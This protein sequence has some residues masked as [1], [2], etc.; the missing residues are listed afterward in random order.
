MEYQLITS[1]Q[2]YLT[3]V[4]RWAWIGTL[5]VIG[6]WV[7]TWSVEQSQLWL[8]SSPAGGGLA[9]QWLYDLVTFLSRHS[10]VYGIVCFLTGMLIRTLLLRTGEPEK[11]LQL[12]FLPILLFIVSPE[13]LL[14]S[15]LLILV[16]SFLCSYTQ[17][18]YILPCSNKFRDI[19]CN[20]LYPPLTISLLIA[21]VVFYCQHDMAIG[22]DSHTIF[23]ISLLLSGIFSLPSLF[24]TWVW[25]TALSVPD[26]AEPIF[27]NI[28]GK[29]SLE[30]WLEWLA[31]DE[32]IAD[33]SDLLGYHEYKS[34]IAEQ[35]DSNQNLR[36][37]L[38]NG[39]YGMGKTSIAKMVISGNQNSTVKQP[40]MLCEFKSWGRGKVTEPN[41]LLLALL[42]DIF[43]SLSQQ[44]SI[45]AIQRL[46]QQIVTA[47]QG[48]SMTKWAVPLMGGESNID[49][50]IEKWLMIM[51][52]S[53]SRIWIL[54]EDLDRRTSYSDDINALM[55]FID[56][57]A[58]HPYAQHI[59][60]VFTLDDSRTNLSSSL[61]IPYFRIDLISTDQSRKYIQTVVDS[62]I[63]CAEQQLKKEYTYCHGQSISVLG[64]DFTPHTKGDSDY[65]R[66]RYYMREET[67]VALY[68]LLSSPRVLKNILREIGDLLLDVTA[69]LHCQVV[70]ED[71]LLLTTL[72]YQAPMVFN[73]IAN[74]KER[75]YITNNIK[76]YIERKKEEKR[77][78]INSSEL[79][80]LY[81][82][83]IS[84]L[85]QSIID[86]KTEHGHS[87]SIDG[88]V[89]ATYLLSD[90][91]ELDHTYKIRYQHP[92][93]RCF[94]APDYFIPLM[95]SG[96]A[97]DDA[98]QFQFGM[99]GLFK[100]LNDYAFPYGPDRID[101]I[102]H[103]LTSSFFENK[104][105][106]ESL[107]PI[108]NSLILH[109]FK[110]NNL[111]EELDRMLLLFNI[112]YSLGH[113][114]EAI[115]SALNSVCNNVWSNL[116]STF[117]IFNLVNHG[118]ELS[119][120]RR[121]DFKFDYDYFYDVFIN[122]YNDLNR[123]TGMDSFNLGNEIVR[124]F[125]FDVMCDKVFINNEDWHLKFNENVAKDHQEKYV[126]FIFENKSFFEKIYS[127]DSDNKISFKKDVEYFEDYK[128]RDYNV[129]MGIN[130]SAIARYH[131]GLNL[132]PEY[133]QHIGQSI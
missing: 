43:T 28:S 122:H 131:F 17:G 76:N 55:P 91:D 93:V 56:Q 125:Y 80:L 107:I 31:S 26:M 15:A 85:Q 89:I 13:L 23:A 90:W 48:H 98:N 79:S 84:Q 104:R 64:S 6:Y 22:T 127:V 130:V 69:P 66:A 62:F 99:K 14:C 57:V 114:L 40:W 105:V 71:L 3:R 63:S 54:I 53:N 94:R 119:S 4:Y 20:V 7:L 27:D 29:W 24:L 120:Y 83:S 123:F 8:N 92:P 50:L 25:S 72:K 51:A 10:L 68:N 133:I 124:Q 52:A 38:I 30:K 118:D 11:T 59:R 101:I 81:R 44:I 74:N 110:F 121:H 45:S 32:H 97:P 129:S 132:Y 35:F 41:S 1:K 77:N 37:V 96:R 18:E 78:A 100:Y 58:R 42:D 19:I 106:S 36:A 109:N 65:Y 111:S 102:G 115:P 108:L 33:E 2:H 73:L 46:P 67:K 128:K 70:A 117:K 47:L 87:L 21:L 49:T 60:F 9:S 61:R 103:I 112:N 82:E 116:A 88:L 75:K 39:Y 126:E 113:S 12:F 34:R 86:T 5:S 95:I 16:C